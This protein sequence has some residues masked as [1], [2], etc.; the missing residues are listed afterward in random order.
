[1]RYFY[2]SQLH[3]V[4]SL[5]QDSVN[6]PDVL[7]QMMDLINPEDDT[8]LKLSDFTKPD[9]RAVS[10]I[11]FDVLFNLNKFMRFESRDPFQEKMKRDD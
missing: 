11:L 5:G 7:C 6:F 3:R 9:K 1:M 2:K 8:A 4:T 10:G